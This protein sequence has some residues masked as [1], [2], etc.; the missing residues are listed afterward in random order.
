MCSLLRHQFLQD[1][2]DRVAPGSTPVRRRRN[3]SSQTQS[4]RRRE[5]GEALT[6]E[7]YARELVSGELAQRLFAITEKIHKKM[8]E[9]LGDGADLSHNAFPALPGSHLRLT[10]PALEFVKA[11]HKA[12]Y[13][14]R[15]SSLNQ[16]ILTQVFTSIGALIRR[17]HPGGGQQVKKEPAQVD[18]RGGV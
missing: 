17:R 18:R 10:N 13:E 8:P 14:L 16:E 15:T 5:A 12:S 7:E 1:E 2:A 3:A 9:Q 4:Q 6:V 11:L